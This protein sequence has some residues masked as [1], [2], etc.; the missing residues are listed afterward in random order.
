M[1]CAALCNPTKQ[2]AAQPCLTRV[3]PHMPSYF[4]R[5]S[6]SIAMAGL[7]DMRFHQRSR[8]RLEVTV[9]SLELI[10]LS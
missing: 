6:E 3:V 4:Y 2:H 8:M 9:A 7:G 10:S 5:D 1:Y